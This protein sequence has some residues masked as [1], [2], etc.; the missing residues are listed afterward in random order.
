VRFT[1]G[2]RPDLDNRGLLAQHNALCVDKH[3]EVAARIVQKRAL[4]FHLS[5]VATPAPRKPEP[6]KTPK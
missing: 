2:A 5:A 1:A 6:G 4:C 3:G